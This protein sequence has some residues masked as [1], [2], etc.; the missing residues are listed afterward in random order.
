MRAGGRLGVGND[1]RY[2]KSRC[3]DPFPFPE[4]SQRLQHEIGDLAEELDGLRK[5]VLSDHPDLTLTGL[6]NVMEDLRAGKE[7]SAKNRDVQARGRVLTLRDLH[8]RI[9][10]AV[11]RAYGWEAN[12]DEASILAALV[13]LNANRVAEERQ[14]LVRWLRPEYQQ[15]KLGPLV[16]RAERIETLPIAAA[17]RR[18]AEL[19]A[20]TREQVSTIVAAL[21]GNTMPFTFRDITSQFRANEK[22]VVEQVLAALAADQGEISQ[23]PDGVH[24]VRTPTAA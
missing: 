23:L 15:D 18:R 2:S 4:A 17:R 20:D 19:S 14:G 1:P 16:H 9:D 8:D 12:A 13:D 24:Y 22:P 3:F 21:P 11:V 10:A 7:L 6:Y 5:H